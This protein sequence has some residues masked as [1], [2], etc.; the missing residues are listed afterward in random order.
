MNHTFGVWFP[1]SFTEGPTQAQ[2]WLNIQVC[3]ERGDMW[4]WQMARCWQWVARRLPVSWFTW[5]F[6]KHF[7]QAPLEKA[8]PWCNLI[9]GLGDTV[10]FLHESPQTMGERSV[11]GQGSGGRA[12]RRGKGRWGG[13]VCVGQ[14]WHLSSSLMTNCSSQR[15]LSI[16]TRLSTFF[17]FFMSPLRPHVVTGI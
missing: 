17:F 13:Y 9:P 3:S 11:T 2:H 5:R 16:Q 10:M 8:S 7:G 15:S 14:A 12:G 1:T 6:I 4:Q